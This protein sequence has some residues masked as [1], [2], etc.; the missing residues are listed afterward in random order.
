[1]EL[2]IY[3]LIGIGAFL[4]LLYLFRSI[5][6]IPSFLRYQKAQIRLLEEIAKKQGVEGA[7]V[8]NIISE[9][10]GWGTAPEQNGQSTTPAQ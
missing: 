3:I 8:Q 7:T 10:I 5:F 4:F 1:M 9:S 6:N 2:F